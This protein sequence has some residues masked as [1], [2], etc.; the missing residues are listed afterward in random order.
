MSGR[1]E[2]HE[3]MF[4]D[5]TLQAAHDQFPRGI[6]LGQLL[7]LGA[8]ANGYR[9]NHSTEVTIEAQRAAFGMVGPQQ[10]Q[11]TA[12]STVSIPDVLAA[13]ANK[14]LHEGWMAVDMTPMAISSI[15]NVRNFQQTTTVSLTG[16]LQFEELGASGEIKHGEVADLTYTNQ[17]DTYAKMLAVTRKDL[18]NDDLGALTAVPRRLGRG[19]AL[20]LNDIFWTVFLNNSTFFT[21]GR[22]NVN[23]AVADITVGGLE[24]TETIFMDQ[25]DPDGKPLGV[26]PSI[27]LVPTAIKA[28]TL[29][30]MQSERLIDGTATAVRGD[31]NVYRGRWRVESS[32]YMSNSSYTGYSAAAWYLLADPGVM[33]VIE[34]AALN[35]NV[36]PVVETADADFNVLGIQMRGYSDV[37]VALQEYRGG[38]R[39]DGG[40]S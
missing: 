20:K 36:M 11:G 18:I 28:A 22:A 9:G 25:T 32:P 39:A 4:D 38:V 5:Q 30:L 29:A 40:A 13:T 7:L 27:I 34:I 1:L 21:A 26:L 15:R 12:F 19:G 2:D 16:H 37:G 24:A 23:T 3:K 31:A 14:F 33:P 17:A 6:G 10:I 35:G 8:E